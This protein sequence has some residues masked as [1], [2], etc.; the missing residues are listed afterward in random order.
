MDKNSIKE[1]INYII[2]GIATTGIS[3]VTYYLCVL[4]FL[5]P[6][7]AW[8]LQLANVISWITAVTFAYF[9]NRK[10]VFKS[11]DPNVLN[12]GI[13]F[14]ASR[15]GTLLMDMGSMFLLVTVL[16][17]N[18]KLSKLAVQFLVIVCN[19]IFSKLFVF[20]KKVGNDNINSE[21]RL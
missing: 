11:R 5:N 1:I 6:Y 2:V 20:G 4:L 13:K 17:L 10:Y 21:E 7:I 18:D 15:I 8:Q 3:L 19:Y 14:F 9:S 12:E 16:G